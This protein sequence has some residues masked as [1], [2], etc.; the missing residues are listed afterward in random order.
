[1]NVLSRLSGLS[2]F[3]VNYYQRT[4]CNV[5]PFLSRH[6]I[7]VS[8][9]LILIQTVSWHMT[10]WR[11]RDTVT[12][13]TMSWHDR[14]KTNLVFNSTKDET[15]SNPGPR[16]QRCMKVCTS[17]V[18]LI[19]RHRVKFPISQSPLKTWN[20]TRDVS[21]FWRV[22]SKNPSFCD[23]GGVPL[24]ISTHDRMTT[25][26]KWKLGSTRPG[27][28]GLDEVRHMCFLW[29]LLWTCC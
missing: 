10:S 5:I 9:V 21:H 7:A 3:L 27:I 15:R 22:Q 29:S 13:V 18:E 12:P 23:A 25:S 26:V 2:V 24:N 6:D 1:M 20:A 16:M 14:N 11:S 19:V 28:L 4:C 8:H 17:Q